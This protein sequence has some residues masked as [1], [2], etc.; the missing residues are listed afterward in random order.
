MPHRI[1]AFLSRETPA[2]RAHF[3]GKARQFI[4]NDN[5]INLL[6]NFDVNNMNA[7]V[8]LS[9]QFMA[10]EGIPGLHEQVTAWMNS[11]VV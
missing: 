6:Q 2:S 10:F 8:R 11:R 5:L 3:I 1:Y 7:N 9:S 4:Q